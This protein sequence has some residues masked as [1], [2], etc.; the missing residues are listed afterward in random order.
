MAK[1]MRSLEDEL[2]ELERTDPEVGA[3]RNSYDRM[4]DRI[5]GRGPALSDEEVRQIY[6]A[7]A[8]AD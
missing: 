5:V 7:P 2:R 8:E 4:V 6:D 3:A 1:H